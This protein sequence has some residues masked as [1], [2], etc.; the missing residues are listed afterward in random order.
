MVDCAK[1]LEVSAVDI[2]IFYMHIVGSYHLNFNNVR[3]IH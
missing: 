3:K 1:L 2:V